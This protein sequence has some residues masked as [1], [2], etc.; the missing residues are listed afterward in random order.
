MRTIL[1]ASAAFLTIF[2]ISGCGDA[3]IREGAIMRDGVLREGIHLKV[4]P[5]AVEV[6]EG[7][8]QGP[9]IKVEP[10]AVNLE[11][12]SGAV[13]FHENSININLVGKKSPRIDT[14][15]LKAALEA[16]RPLD[17]QGMPDELKNQV[18]ANEA[19][20]QATITA[21]LKMIDEY[22]QNYAAP[23]KDD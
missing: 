6:K 10:R 5:G 3:H 12:A 13:Q 8:F 19:L 11:V 4:E 9:A 20:Y 16:L 18:I 14:K 2:A 22:N 15:E 1:L 17:L 23:E 7:A 21:L